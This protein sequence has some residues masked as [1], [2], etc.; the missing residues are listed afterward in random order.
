M[1]DWIK[2]GLSDD[3]GAM[4]EARVMAVITIL[5][6]LGGSIVSMTQGHWSFREFGE[7]VGAMGIGLGVW[8]G[9]RGKN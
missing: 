4:D 2:K 3:V 1:I 5:T 8:M 9:G 7:G 6:Y